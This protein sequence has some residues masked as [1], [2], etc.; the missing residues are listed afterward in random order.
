MATITKLQRPDGTVYKARIRRH[1][2]EGETSRTFKT[3]NAAERWARKVESSIEQ[4]DAGLVSVAQK[5]T[6]N[7]AIDRYRRDLL[8]GL[9][10]TTIPNYTRHLIYWG[11]TLGHLRLSDL[12]A[13]KIAAC[14]DDLTIVP[15]AGKTPES[16]PACRAP[17]T[18]R[19]YLATLAA[20]LT[21][22][23]QEWHWLTDTPMRQVSKP[24][25]SNA[26]SR[27]LSEDELD[28]LLTACRASRSPDLLLAVMLSITTGARQGEILGLRWKDVDL[29]AGVLRLRVDN[30][31]TTKGGIR[32]LPIVSQV[33]PLLADR[34]TAYR[35]GKV[36]DLTGSG[37]VFP[38]RV[39]LNQPVDLR[40][41]F[42]TALERAGIEGFVWHD[43]RHS[44]ASFMA[45]NG[46]SLLEIGAVLGHK[47][48][49]TTA[50]YAHLAEQASHA[51]VRGTADKVLG[52]R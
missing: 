11:D 20:V 31:T 48:A 32:S 50:R 45:A 7:E 25:V 5:H 10:P 49:Q 27:F 40:K 13:A 17:A 44:A 39:S 46:A 15:M 38:S 2:S 21:A 8:P 9:N 35:Q 12:T 29:T 47:C 4:D 14:R 23:Q 36:A 52:G 51:L 19:R 16:I 24:S 37:L 34:L 30:E 28:R 3:R 41:P 6:L 22:C 42:E 18:V 1:G 33:R 43:L 26:R